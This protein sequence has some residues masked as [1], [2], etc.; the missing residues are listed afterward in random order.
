[1]IVVYVRHYLILEDAEAKA[2]EHLKD[3]NEV[4]L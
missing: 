1:M 4:P 2:T 3:W